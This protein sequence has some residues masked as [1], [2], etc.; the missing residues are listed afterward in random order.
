MA[1]MI[2]FPENSYIEI[3]T[4]KVMVLEGGFLEDD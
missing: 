4:P 3:L 1:W 2:V